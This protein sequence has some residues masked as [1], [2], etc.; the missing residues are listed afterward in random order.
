MESSN[1]RAA[2][3]SRSQPQYVS[4]GNRQNRKLISKSLKEMLMESFD[5]SIGTFVLLVGPP[6]V[7]TLRCTRQL[8]SYCRSAVGR[9][10]CCSN[11]LFCDVN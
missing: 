7:L 6:S 3:M 4:H 9:Q 5:G 11:H 2:L 1:R 10:P 8:N